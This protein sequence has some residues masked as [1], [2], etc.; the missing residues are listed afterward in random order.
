M[1]FDHI[2]G[3]DRGVAGAGAGLARRHPDQALTRRHDIGKVLGVHLRPTVEPGRKERHR[4]SG[5]GRQGNAV[6]TS[7]AV[8][9][10]DQHRLPGQVASRPTAFKRERQSVLKAGLI[11][12]ITRNDRRL[13][14]EDVGDARLRAQQVD[15][16]LNVS[17]LGDLL[18]AYDQRTIDANRLVPESE[19]VRALMS[20]SSCWIETPGV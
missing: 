3:R 6:E 1:N 18:H 16:W 13:A 2:I 10:A 17:V 15:Q 14:R 19:T 11:L 4:L 7:E 12:A 5:S 8:V 9:R 20:I